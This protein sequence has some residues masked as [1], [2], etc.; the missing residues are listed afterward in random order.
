MEEKELDIITKRIQNDEKLKELYKNNPEEAVEMA[1]ATIDVDNFSYQLQERTNIKQE[2][3]DLKEK[4]ELLNEKGDSYGY[5]I[6]KDWIKLKEMEFDLIGTN[7]EELQKVLDEEARIKQ[8][9]H[10]YVEDLKKVEEAM[11]QIESR[12]LEN[13][14]KEEE[15]YKEHQRIEKAE[16]EELIRRSV[17]T[18]SFDSGN[19]PKM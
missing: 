16:E 19:G 4:L 7:S 1:K 11:Y 3:D 12:Y 6:I 8:E 5:G 15:G 18:N 9:Y 13:F 10:E 14:A 2:L 17:E